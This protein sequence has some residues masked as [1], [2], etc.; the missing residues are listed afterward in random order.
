MKSEGKRKIGAKP[1]LHRTAYTIVKGRAHR[2][3][4]FPGKDAFPMKRKRAR[5]PTLRA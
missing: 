5:N 4:R 3:A 2:Q 1:G